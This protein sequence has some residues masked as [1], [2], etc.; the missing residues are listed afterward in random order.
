MI[1][2]LI[3]YLKPCSAITVLRGFDTRIL[4]RATITSYTI[5]GVTVNGNWTMQQFLNELNN[6]YS[7]SAFIR[8]L[9]TDGAELIFTSYKNKLEKFEFEYSGNIYIIN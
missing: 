2:K 1:R 7:Q 8:T 4:N 3:N 5:N 6:G 9:P